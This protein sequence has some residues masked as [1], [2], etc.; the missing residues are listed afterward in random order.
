VQLHSLALEVVVFEFRLK[1][2]RH[3]AL[4]GE[5]EKTSLW[6]LDWRSW[7]TWHPLRHAL[8]WRPWVPSWW[9]LIVIRHFYANI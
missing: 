2:D 3:T 9:L 8:R 7:L 4:T 6:L 5:F 1:S